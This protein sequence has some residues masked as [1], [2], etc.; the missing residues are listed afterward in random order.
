MESIKELFK[1][2]QFPVTTPM[3]KKQCAECNI[4][5]RDFDSLN[6]LMEYPCLLVLFNSIH[7]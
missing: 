3:P 6:N 4:L 5:P 7:S 1:A 2:T